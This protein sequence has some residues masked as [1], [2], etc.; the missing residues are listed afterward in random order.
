MTTINILRR[1]VGISSEN[2]DTNCRRIA[3]FTQDFLKRHTQAQVI[4]QTTRDNN[5]NVIAR[6]GHPRFFL[7]AHLDTVPRSVR[8]VKPLGLRQK[9]DKLYGL[10]TTDVK[11]AIACQLSV[12][13]DAPPKNLLVIYTCD[14]EAGANEGIRTFLASRY[15]R[16]LESGIVTEPTNLNVV[17][18]HSGIA[19]FE[20]DFLGRAAHS[21][22]PQRGVNAI[23]MAAAYIMALVRYQKKIRPYG[24]GGLQP[25]VNSAVIS[26]GIKSNIVPDHCHLKIG[27]R[28]L[29]GLAPERLL[30]DLRDLVPGRKISIRMTYNAPPLRPNP[31][32]AAAVRYLHRAGAASDRLC[33]NYWSEA[34]L[35]DRHGIPAVVF[36]P[37][38]IKQAHAEDEFISRAQLSKAEGMYRK[39]FGLL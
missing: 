38:D 21:A 3:A 15:G 27:I 13:A 37:G 25:A 32:A 2:P 31:A 1:L 29:T 26:G 8:S 17:R 11:G 22:Y 10:G 33:V 14:E 20:I 12:L 9:G 6:F 36:G 24:S 19:N 39:L 18:C 23:E 35:F 28:Y 34:A 4:G 30:R 16:G 5:F 7:N